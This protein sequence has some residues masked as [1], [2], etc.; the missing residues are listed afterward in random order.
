MNAGLRL[1]VA[2]CECGGQIESNLDLEAIVTQ[3]SD[4]PEVTTIRRLRF[5]C[6]PDGIDALQATIAEAGLDEVLVAGC[7]PRT[8][9]PRFRAACEEVGLEGNRFKLVDIREGCAWVHQGTIEAATTKAT[10]LIRMGISELRMRGP[11]DPKTV[12]IV[13]SALVIGGGIAGMTASL[14]LADE[15]VPVVIVEREA[16]LGGKIRKTDEKANGSQAAMLKA[17]DE[18]PRI[19]VLLEKDIVDVTGTVGRYSVRVNGETGRKNG[20]QELEVGAI[21]VAT[22]VQ[23][24]AATLAFKLG[25]PQDQNGFFPSVRQRLRPGH[26]VDRGIYVCGAAH[27]P[28]NEHEAEFQGVRAAYGALTHLSAGTVTNQ[29]S[30]AVVNRD[31]CTGC[32]SCVTACPFGAISMYSKSGLLDEAKVDSL[33]CSECGNCLVVCPPRA[34]DLPTAGDAAVF[35]QIESALVSRSINDHQ[36]VLVFGCEWSNQLAADLAGA[37]RLSYPVGIRLIKM[38]CSA[39]FDPAFALWA[40]HHGAD[41]VLLTACPP[42]NCHYAGGNQHAQIR[43]ETLRTQLDTS[44]FDARRLEL[45]WI[46]PDDAEDFV[47]KV[48]RFSELMAQVPPRR[49]H[50]V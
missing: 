31:L 5:G 18:H 37:R 36:R 44:G 33:L 26:Y 25:I 7:T 32:A 40:F 47:D 43:I 24:D 9:E 12:E 3:I 28:I 29:A 39:R 46:Q 23:P 17:V 41:G 38:Q 2:I 34:I 8:L 19:D 35:S 45:E 27:S 50:A 11:H 22:G 13:H 15:G 20:A 21:I 48:S 30:A 6:S 10:D 16:F 49:V 14:T 42:G 1:G 4:L